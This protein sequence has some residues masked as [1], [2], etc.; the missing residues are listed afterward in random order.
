MLFAQYWNDLPL[1]WPW[2]KCYQLELNQVQEQENWLMA[3][4]NVIVSAFDTGMLNA[5]LQLH[6]H[7]IRDLCVFLPFPGLVIWHAGAPYSAF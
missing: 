3:N 5:T 4:E 7:K 6:S 2:L 1:H